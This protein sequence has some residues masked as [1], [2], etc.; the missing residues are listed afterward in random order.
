MY[1]NMGDVDTVELGRCMKN[2]FSLVA[3][4]VQDGFATIQSRK[5]GSICISLFRKKPFFSEPCLVVCFQAAEETSWDTL[6]F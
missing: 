5:L 4:S 1:D 6:A 3:F 2:I